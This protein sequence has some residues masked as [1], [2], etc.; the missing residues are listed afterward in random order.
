MSV[1]DEPLGGYTSIQYCIVGLVLADI[2]CNLSV[3]GFVCHVCGFCQVSTAAAEYSLE[4]CH[5][6]VLVCQNS[7][8]EGPPTLALKVHYQC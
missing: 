4:V 3:A 2:C 1:A 6:F 8:L 7:V 5:W